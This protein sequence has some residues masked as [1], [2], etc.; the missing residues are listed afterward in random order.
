MKIATTMGVG[1]LIGAGLNVVAWTT[2][3][4]VGREAGMWMLLFS[5]P[6]FLFNVDYRV[7]YELDYLVFGSII[8]GVAGAL[9]AL[10]V[11]AF[12][13]VVRRW[14]VRV[15]ALVWTA[16][17]VWLAIA[18]LTGPCYAGSKRDVWLTSP[19]WLAPAAA[20][21]SPWLCGVLL[22]SGAM[23]YAVHGLGLPALGLGLVVCAVAYRR[24]RGDTHRPRLLAAEARL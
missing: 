1:A 23:S 13:Q 21:I 3:E 6:V 11:C 12:P 4:A 9:V 19:L 18:V 17:W 15:L 7:A 10:L 2:L 22:L 5:E 16:F 20:L 24:G 14:V 8:Y